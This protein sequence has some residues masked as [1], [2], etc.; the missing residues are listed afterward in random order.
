MITIVQTQSE[1]DAIPEPKHLWYDINRI[2]VYTGDDVPVTPSSRIVTINEFRDKF[3]T[4]EQDA[5]LSLAYSGDT[6]ARRFLL[7]LQTTLMEVDLD[8]ADVVG[9]L[10]YL[11]AK[12][13][14]TNSRANEIRA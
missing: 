3:T 8:H 2:V 9:A 11:V 7:K 4:T 1:A 14:L 6:V 13:V 10:A 5:I 12:S